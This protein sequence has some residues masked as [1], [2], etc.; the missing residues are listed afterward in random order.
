MVSKKLSRLSDEQ[1]ITL[2]YALNF[3]HVNE[4]RELCVKLQLIDTGMKRALVNRIVHFVETGEVVVEP[5]PPKISCA[6]RGKLYPLAPDTLIL[7]GAYKNDLQTR[8]FFKQLIGDYFHFTAFGIDWLNDRWMEGNPST[9]REFADMWRVEYARRK[10][11]GTMPKEE[12]AYITYVQKFI[13][14]H[15]DA[16]RKV[17]MDAWN[18]E[19]VRQVAVVHAL[20]KNA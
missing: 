14:E 17:I 19:R 13:Q 3:L 8:L 11:F 2:R 4:L 16:S 15:P 12:W 1:L 7:K 6:Q 9:Y 5:K 18:N 10:Q 20:L